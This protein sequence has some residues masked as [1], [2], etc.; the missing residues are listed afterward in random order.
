MEV[1][2]I[3]DLHS[4]IVH[5]GSVH[6]GHYYC[7]VKEVGPALPADVATENPSYIAADGTVVT[8]ASPG[9][10][11]STTKP[12]SPAGGEVAAAAQQQSPKDDLDF[13]NGQWY[14]L[15]D[16]HVR[17][18]AEYD[19][20]NLNFGGRVPST[21]GGYSSTIAT[22]SAY[23]LT[24]IRRG[25]WKTIIRPTPTDS[26]PQRV[27]DEFRRV[28]AEEDN[29]RRELAEEAKRCYVSVVDDTHLFDFVRRNSHD[30]FYS[31]SKADV[32]EVIPGS[33]DSRA[34]RLPR[35]HLIV[36]QKQEPFAA[37]YD[38]LQEQCGYDK[39]S[40]R[41]RGWHYHFDGP[42]PASY[43]P[44]IPLVSF[45][46]STGTMG[47]VLQDMLDNTAGRDTKT[48][49]AGK[50]IKALLYIEQKRAVLLP[51]ALPNAGGKKAAEGKDQVRD[52]SWNLLASE[53]KLIEEALASSS[54]DDSIHP[55][56]T[57]MS[58]KAH[59]FMSRDPKPT[60]TLSMTQ[61]RIIKTL[62]V[63]FSV[64]KHSQSVNYMIYADGFA[65]PE[66]FNDKKLAWRMAAQQQKL[67]Y[68]TQNGTCYSQN[69]VLVHK[70]TAT[71]IEP[72]RVLSIIISPSAN[73]LMYV[74]VTSI[75]ISAIYADEEAEAGLTNKPEGDVPKATQVDK[76]L[77][78][79][80][81]L[82]LPPIRNADKS[83][84][85]MIK[86]FLHSPSNGE[87]IRYLGP[88]LT[89]EREPLAAYAMHILFLMG[90]PVDRLAP[91]ERKGLANSLAYYEERRVSE[92][93]PLDP[94]MPMSQ[95]SLL[96][97]NIIIVE[98]AARGV[99]SL[100]CVPT[101]ISHFHLLQNQTIVTLR[102]RKDPFEPFLQC[103]MD[104]RWT[105]HEV[106]EAISAKIGRL[107]GSPTGSPAKDKHNA[108]PTSSSASPLDMSNP[109][110]ID[111]DKIVLYAPIDPYT[112]NIPA[113]DPI[114]CTSKDGASLQSILMSSGNRYLLRD[115]FFEILP[116]PRLQMEQR[117]QLKATIADENGTPLTDEIFVNLDP[118]SCPPQML[119]ALFNAA[120]E[121]P[122]ILANPTMDNAL[123]HLANTAEA[124][125]LVATRDH[126]VVSIMDNIVIGFEDEQDDDEEEGYSSDSDNAS[127]SGSHQRKLHKAKLRA[128]PTNMKP[129]DP[130][131]FRG[132][133]DYQ[134]R[135][136]N[137][138]R[139]GEQRM[140]VGFCDCP[141]M[142]YTTQA[143][144]FGSPII[145]TITDSCSLSDTWALLERQFPHFTK[146][147][148]AD[149][150]KSDGLCIKL[151]M[152]TD[153]ALSFNEWNT[154]PVADYFYH[155]RNR[156]VYKPMLCINKPKPKDTKGSKDTYST[157]EPKL[158]L[159]DSAPPVT[160]KE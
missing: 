18:V 158:R 117:V 2:P 67:P 34:S 157:A 71:E 24:Y 87:H 159:G 19:A 111:P 118:G 79:S 89:D 54:Y 149:P 30:L 122:S 121:Q 137:L 104:L 152:Y 127:G 99:S 96:N 134:I 88:L 77:Q 5:K 100:T 148:R 66:A 70:P 128:F 73:S 36:M 78:L 85:L 15:D 1:P 153:Q 61:S 101:V 56:V 64:A 105:Y 17:N 136:L 16:D 8:D 110:I 59:N 74:P 112:P 27:K 39:N 133:M 94:L 48:N 92:I 65:T 68:A 109:F 120:R 14:E 125:C 107:A 12:A 145:L 62:V 98:M 83:L 155:T 13:A 90:I 146:N 76:N 106:C 58:S 86:G 4:I 91:A 113:S 26:I 57:I 60:L 139:K 33:I 43:R 35:S 25:F 72:V 108:S 130:S 80:T 124:F 28:M 129:L 42:R 82:T 126:R 144:L 84:L 103:T 20:I 95:Q 55:K 140:F 32:T 141:Q 38:K 93:V 81:A 97:G 119:L 45:D 142:Q 150:Q 115:L 23:M 49:P 37:L 102:A 75:Q 21:Y 22:N 50:P 10:A 11:H 147:A 135:P 123:V 131:A 3:Y 156:S 31:S 138:L 41:I 29:R 44:N 160:K 143:P 132:D 69:F 52:F 53:P 154:T 46:E 6:N 47:E 116:M 7:Y 114:K 151:V 63:R 51:P 9:E 40:I